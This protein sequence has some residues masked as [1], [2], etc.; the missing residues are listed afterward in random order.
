MLLKLTP[1]NL[2]ATYSLLAECAPFNQWPLPDA[3]DV[4]FVVFRAKD[5]AADCSHDGK[6]WV[7]RVNES[8]CASLHGLIRHMAHEMCHVVHGE[9]C[10]NDQAMHGKWFKALAHAVCKVHGWDE[11][12]F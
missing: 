10:P 6:Q 9:A 5:R 2:E 8:W 1:D 12:A 3:Q 7:I 4:K 11:K